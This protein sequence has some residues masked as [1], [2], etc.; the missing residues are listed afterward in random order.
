MVL[1]A[2]NEADLTRA[3]EDIRSHGGRAVCAVAATLL[4][5]RKGRP[6]IEGGEER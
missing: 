2:R 5:R 6:T 3:V 4:G 1:A